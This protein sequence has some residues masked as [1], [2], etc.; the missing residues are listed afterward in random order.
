[1]KETSDNIDGLKKQIKE[2]EAANKNL[3][4]KNEMTEL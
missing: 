1:M 2:L 3:T 4:T